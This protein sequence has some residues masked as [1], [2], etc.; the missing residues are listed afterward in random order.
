MSQ[1]N[2]L[3]S[4]HKHN[5]EGFHTFRR[6]RVTRL[7]GQVMPEDIRKYWI[8]HAEGSVT[9]L[10]NNMDQRKAERVRYAEAVGLGYELPSVPTLKA[11]QKASRC[12]QCAQTDQVKTKAM[13]A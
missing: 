4:L 10:Y 13:A 12:A 11:T 5:V 6:F 3:R 7:R 9:G 8:G 1:R 2:L